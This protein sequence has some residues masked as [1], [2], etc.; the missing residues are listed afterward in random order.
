M[1]NAAEKKVVLLVLWTL[2]GVVFRE[3][4]AFVWDA[5]TAV[6]VRVADSR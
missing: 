2:R 3:A 5:F 1:N 6:V 4:T